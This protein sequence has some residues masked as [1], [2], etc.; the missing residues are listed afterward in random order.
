MDMNS[1][2][3]FGGFSALLAVMKVA[4]FIFWPWWT[5]LIPLAFALFMHLMISITR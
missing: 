1:Y 2:V 3:F 4:G 5:T